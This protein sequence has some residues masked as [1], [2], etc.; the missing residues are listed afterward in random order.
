MDFGAY[1]VLVWKPGERRP[2]GKSRCRWKKILK[3][4]FKKG[5][6]HKLD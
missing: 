1:N 3:W 4:I 5:M 2:L 6:G